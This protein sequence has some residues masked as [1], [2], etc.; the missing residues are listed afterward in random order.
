MGWRLT[1]GRPGLSMSGATRDPDPTRKRDDDGPST[2]VDA[3][4]PAPNA[5]NAHGSG[6]PSITP[7]STTAASPPEPGRSSDPVQGLQP[8]LGATIAT[9]GEAEGGM[10]SGLPP[11]FMSEP[12]H[13]DD[14]VTSLPSTLGAVLAAMLV[15]AALAWSATA[16]A[17]VIA[18]AVYAPDAWRYGLW[19][20]FASATG[21]FAAHRYGGAASRD[22]WVLTFATTISGVGIALGAVPSL[23][24]PELVHSVVITAGWVCTAFSL[25]MIGGTALRRAD[26]LSALAIGASAAGGAGAF[27][28]APM[29]LE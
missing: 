4:S 11:R 26:H 13:R 19:A 16:M 21:M 25:G 14:A 3:E 10:G 28:T 18:V 6:I 20:T 7:V 9:L 27:A 8:S 5:E 2:P 1:N 15:G 22:A 17:R 23:V 24:V 29:L 12:P